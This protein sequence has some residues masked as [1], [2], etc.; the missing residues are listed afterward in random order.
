M[1]LFRRIKN[2][3][4]EPRKQSNQNAANTSNRLVPLVD[5]ELPPDHPR[6]V[7]FSLLKDGGL[8]VAFY[9]PY[10]AQRTFDEALRLAPELAV[11]DPLSDWFMKLRRDS[12]IWGVVE[13][14]KGSAVLIFANADSD[15]GFILTEFMKNLEVAPP[16]F[17]L[18]LVSFAQVPESAQA[19][20]SLL[21]SCSL[22]PIGAD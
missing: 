17:E 3:Q 2:A 21:D 20:R 15:T 9:S 7:V 1:A 10:S 5:P 22:V 4:P 19:L 14:E 11:S 18:T 16:P 12:S 13:S 6:Q 8:T